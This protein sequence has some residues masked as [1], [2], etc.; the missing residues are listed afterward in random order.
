M[1]ATYISPVTVCTPSERL[2]FPLK[3]L[4]RTSDYSNM[5]LKSYHMQQRSTTENLW[6][7]PQ[8]LGQCS[9]KSQLSCLTRRRSMEQKRSKHRFHSCLMFCLKERVRM[10][11]RR[12]A[13]DSQL[14][15][16]ESKL[17]E[18]ALKWFTE[19]QA[20]LILHEGNFPAWFQGFI[21]RKDAEDH[22][23]DKEVG[24]FLI[25]LSDKA[26]GY[27]LSYRGRDRCRHFVINQNKEGQFIVTGDT[28]MHD[29]LTSLIEYYKSRPIEPFGEY[30][31]MSCF[32]SSTSD[33]YD[34]VQ[35]EPKGKPGVN[36][37]AARSMWDQRTEQ[38]ASQPQQ[39]PTVP[40]RSN[41]TTQAVP[42][43]PKRTTA[44]KMSSLEEKN[45]SEG[46]VLYAQLE[47]LKPKDRETE[48]RTP[49]VNDRGAPRTSGPQ[50]VRAQR[51]PAPGPG[52]IYSEL[53]LS[54]CRSR[55]LPLLDDNTKEDSSYKLNTPSPS[56]PQLSPNL[57]KDHTR[58]PPVHA[59][60][61]QSH[62]LDKLYDNS[63]Y[64][65]AGQPA[66]PRDTKQA[67]SMTKEQDHN[68]TYA[69][70]PREHMAK[71][72][73]TEENTYEQIPEPRHTPN[74]KGSSAHG[75]TYETLEDCKPKPSE[76]TWGIKG[77]KWKWL[78]PEHW[79]K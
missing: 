24:C 17:R 48:P 4:K 38:P 66:N 57:Q 22:L 61:C 60:P 16:T 40:S 59:T 53:N 34:V 78:L 20:P 47:Q 55:S 36:V 79:K 18:L 26:T 33:L 62:S 65:L 35:F 49:W 30:L 13:A 58:R 5:R 45:S 3:Q 42:P 31:T 72:F 10:E 29:T 69:E 15:S 41:R 8:C 23:R 9:F 75:N 70:V 76:S 63:F 68:V 73:H 37:K 27:I 64:Q 21:S 1:S 46:K 77:D 12:P 52:T 6:H 2:F 51:S 28:E 44:H 11:Q 19:T 7:N 39:P 74:L 67:V 71:R 56:P 43:V 25:R 14:D 32:E 50:R 54:D